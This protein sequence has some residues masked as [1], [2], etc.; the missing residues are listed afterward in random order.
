MP[1]ISQGQSFPLK[2]EIR[3]K[4]N[5]IMVSCS[6]LAPRPPMWK[7]GGKDIKKNKPERHSDREGL[8]CFW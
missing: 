1:R 3:N 2:R 7:M 6:I 5:I 4:P 8:S